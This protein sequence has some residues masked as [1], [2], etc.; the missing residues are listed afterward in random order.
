MARI[1]WVMGSL[2]SSIRQWLVMSQTFN[3]ALFLIDNGEEKI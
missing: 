2:G 3:K 1:A